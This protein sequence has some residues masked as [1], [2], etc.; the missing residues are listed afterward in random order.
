MARFTPGQRVR[1]N[2]RITERFKHAPP[3]HPVVATLANLVGR[4][5]VVRKHD[6]LFSFSDERPEPVCDFN[7]VIIDLHD[8]SPVSVDP[9]CLDLIDG[10]ESLPKLPLGSDAEHS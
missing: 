4:E 2:S 8:G 1:V 6:R 7:T 9:E 10:Q 3:H 5:G